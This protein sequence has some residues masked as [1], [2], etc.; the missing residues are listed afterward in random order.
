LYNIVKY[1]LIFYN[2]LQYFLQ[3]P[4]LAYAQTHI[5][6]FSNFIIC[7]LIFPLRQRKHTQAHTLESFRCVPL[8]ENSLVRE[9]IHRQF[10]LHNLSFYSRLRRFNLQGKSR[11][12]INKKMESYVCMGVIKLL[13]GK[14]SPQ[15]K[16]DIKNGY[17]N[18]KR[19]RPTHNISFM[20][21][22]SFIEF[23]WWNDY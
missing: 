4:G 16:S 15:K 19:H 12:C 6:N 14:F 18:T 22:F 7:N 17:L 23:N 21:V 13:N 9:K 5:K 1:F 2:I 11:S 10:L 8:V 20:W 3:F